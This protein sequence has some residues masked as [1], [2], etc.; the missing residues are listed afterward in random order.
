MLEHSPKMESTR[1]IQYLWEKT[2]KKRKKP[3]DKSLMIA[4]LFK[5][6]KLISEC[7]FMLLPGKAERSEFV[8]LVLL[9]GHFTH[10]TTH[11]PRYKFLML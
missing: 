11:N 10:V 3:Q 4:V 8:P 6:T 7:G 2:L 9:A 1:G 5:I